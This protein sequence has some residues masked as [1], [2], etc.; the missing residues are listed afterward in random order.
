MLQT[1]RVVFAMSTITKLVDIY[2]YFIKNVNDRQNF[3]TL[4][5]ML[6]AYNSNGI[7]FGDICTWILLSTTWKNKL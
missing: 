4:Q 2:F 7:I 3:I 1:I 6:Y 5:H